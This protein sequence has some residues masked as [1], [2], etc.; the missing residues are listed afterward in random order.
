[1]SHHWLRPVARVRWCQE[2]EAEEGQDVRRRSVAV[3]M[4]VLQTAPVIKS[5]SISFMRNP[6]GFGVVHVGFHYSAA[7]FHL[8]A[9]MDFF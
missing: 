4:L 7:D 2:I 6:W 1:M 8:L 5:Q 9:L 3:L